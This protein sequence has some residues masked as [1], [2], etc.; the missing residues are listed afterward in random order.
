M[1]KLQGYETYPL[2]VKLPQYKTL[3]FQDIM[4]FYESNLKNKAMVVSFVGDDSRIPIE[5]LQKYGKIVEIKE[6]NLFTK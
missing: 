2:S 5:D 4:K 1:W 3:C 6:D